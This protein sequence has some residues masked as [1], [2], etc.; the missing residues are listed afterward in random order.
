MPPLIVTVLLAIIWSRY[1]IVYQFCIFRQELLRFPSW[2]LYH[3]MRPLNQKPTSRCGCLATRNDLNK[4]NEQ[5]NNDE[6]K[7]NHFKREAS[8]Y[9]KEEE[10]VCEKKKRI[11]NKRYI[12]GSICPFITPQTFRMSV[13][14]LSLF[15]TKSTRLD[16]K[17]TNFRKNVEERIF[18]N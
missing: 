16:K 6:K 3:S 12:P 15:T 14:L 17:N 18:D 10:E 13:I 2:L 9:F 1:S 5:Q 11:R 7:N 4:K 8:F